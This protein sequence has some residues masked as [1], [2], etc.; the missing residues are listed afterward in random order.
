MS[1]NVM[2]EVHVIEILPGH[3]LVEY[4]DD[5]GYVQRR[6]IPQGLCRI[7]ARG[8][9]TLSAEILSLGM[10][11]SNVDLVQVLGEELPSIRVRD[12]EDHLRRA[13]LWTQQDYQEKTSIVNGV[14]QKLRGVDVT[15][16]VN[17]AL[18]RIG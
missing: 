14:W 8:P 11:Y 5:A 18:T 7:V 16:I 9:A 17:A 13:G 12:L 3:S 10:E 1:K 6:L 2:V 15:T 4:E